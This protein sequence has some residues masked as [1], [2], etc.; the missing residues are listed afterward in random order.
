MAAFV[1]EFFGETGGTSAAGPSENSDNAVGSIISGNMPALKDGR[2]TL[3]I[4]DA[5]VALLVAWYY[6]TRRYQ[7]E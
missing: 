6:F 2:I 3:T 5:L 1:E 4:L 7:G